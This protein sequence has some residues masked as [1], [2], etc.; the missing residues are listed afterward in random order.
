MYAIRSYY[1]GDVVEI[2]L[3]P[4]RTLLVDSPKRDYFEVLR[5]KLRWG[6]R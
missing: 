2:R 3:S 6:E 4:N 5:T 1:G